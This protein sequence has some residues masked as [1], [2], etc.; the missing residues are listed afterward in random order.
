MDQMPA[1]LRPSYVIYIG[2]LPRTTDL[3]ATLGFFES[4]RPIL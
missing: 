2:K 1:G 4:F 3:V